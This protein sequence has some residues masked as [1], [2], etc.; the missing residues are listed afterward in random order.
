MQ[1]SLEEFRNK[2][3]EDVYSVY[4]IFKEFFGEEY[5][6]LQIPEI[7]HNRVNRYYQNIA[8]ADIDEEYINNLKSSWRTIQSDIIV[9]FPTVTIRNEY[10]R[11]IDIEDLFAKITVSLEG[12]IPVEAHGFQLT[13]S[14]FTKEEWESGYIHSHVPILRDEIPSFSHPCLGRGPIRSTIG[15]LK[16]G[17]DNITWMLFCQE[18]ASYVTVESLTGVPYI[19]MENVGALG[20]NIDCNYFYTNSPCRCSDFDYYTE[21][22]SILKDFTLYYLKNGHLKFNFSGSEFCL[23]LSY[24]D[25]IIDIS[26]A[27]IEWYNKECNNNIK[28]FLDDITKVVHVKDGK[29]YSILDNYHGNSIPSNPER[30]RV[31]TFKGNDINLK[32]TD[33]ATELEDC[34]ILDT[35]VANYLLTNVL[36]IINY[37][38]GKRNNESN[39]TSGG[40]VLYI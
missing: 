3:F 38:Y 16:I 17:K 36:R 9:W 39:S 8:D 30:F 23:G 25:Y 1:Y 35:R 18:L 6:D 27:F 5:T 14:T 4:D 33:R 19:K 24:F 31:L 40:D 20:Y 2:I 7:N 21:L 28:K 26:N 11:T 29:F 13:K 10:D 12:T 34:R 22:I 37:H 32:I 15:S